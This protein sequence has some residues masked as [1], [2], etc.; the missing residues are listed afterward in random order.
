MTAHTAVAVA[1]TPRPK[2]AAAAQGCAA[3]QNPP[4][5][6]RPASL[7]K[8]LLALVVVKEL[9]P[10]QVLTPTPEDASQECTCVG[11]SAGEKYTVDQLLHGLLMHS[12][13]DVAHTLATALGGVPET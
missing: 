2:P 1:T 13:N 12:G 3:P 9:Q 7:I 10:D 5:R 11:I 4:P 8:T 6:E